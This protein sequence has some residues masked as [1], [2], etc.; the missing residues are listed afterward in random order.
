MSPSSAICER[1]A[2]RSSLPQAARCVTLNVNS[3][4]SISRSVCRS[5]RGSGIGIFIRPA[6]LKLAPPPHSD[7]SYPFSRASGAFQNCRARARPQR[8]YAPG[9]L[10]LTLC[11][12]RI[13]VVDRG[14]V[15]GC[16]RGVER[17]AELRDV[18]CLDDCAVKRDV[19]ESCR[20]QS[21]GRAHGVDGRAQLR[22]MDPFIGTPASTASTNMIVVAGSMSLTPTVRWLRWP[23]PCTSTSCSR[24][25]HCRW[26]PCWP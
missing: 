1:R 22:D 8:F 7:G 18:Q 12:H 10:D 4:P 24:P 17:C 16:T 23:A 26:W 20:C 25:V 9:T 2:T 11:D 15:Q 13:D 6:A 5:D 14:Q 19:C 3:D 21:R